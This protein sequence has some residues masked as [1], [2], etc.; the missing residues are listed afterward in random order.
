MRSD[1]QRL[2]KMQRTVNW[3]NLH[4][5]E[6]TQVVRVRRDSPGQILLSVGQ[7]TLGL[8][9]LGDLVLQAAFYVRAGGQNEGLS[10]TAVQ[11]NSGLQGGDLVGGDGVHAGFALGGGE[12]VA[13]RAQVAVV[14]VQLLLELHR[15]FSRKENKI[16]GNSKTTEKKL[17]TS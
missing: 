6:L 17:S 12:G 4:A 8:G 3:H 15:L 16:S 14:G 9:Q 5:R 1:K 11:R 2:L 7:V 10:D 13:H